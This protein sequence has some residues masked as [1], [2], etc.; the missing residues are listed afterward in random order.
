MGSNKGERLVFIAFFPFPFLL[1]LLLVCPPLSQVLVPLVL[2]QALQSEGQSVTTLVHLGVRFL[3]EDASVLTLISY[4][5]QSIQPAKEGWIQ[6]L[7]RLMEKFFR[8]DMHKK[9]W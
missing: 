3:E 8:F 9:W 1:L 7:Y 2:L 6:S 5:A 4:R